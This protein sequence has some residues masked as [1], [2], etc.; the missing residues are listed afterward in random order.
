[1]FAVGAS[2]VAKYQVFTSSLA[3]LDY[4]IIYL[5]RTYNTLVLHLSKP[6]APVRE[7]SATNTALTLL[8]DPERDHVADQTAPVRDDSVAFGGDDAYLLP[9]RSIYD[10]AETQFSD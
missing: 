6:F 4:Y 10:E 5:T 2:V 1:M 8:V 3:I 7:H 9:Y